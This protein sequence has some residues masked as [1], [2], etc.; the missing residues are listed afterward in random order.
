MLLRKP[1]IGFVP[2]PLALVD[3]MLT[4]AEV[5]ANDI[6]YDLGSGDG[7]I[8]I[9][10]AQCFGTRGVGLEID[11]DRLREAEV[12]VQRAGVSHLVSFRHQDLFEGNFSEATV[13]ILYLLPHLNL[14]LRPHLLHQLQPG[15]RLISRDFDMGNWLPDRV[16]NVPEPEESVLYY[17]RISTQCST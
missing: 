14:R 16:L 2:T 6:L 3:A 4:L 11:R 5:Q 12:E 15:T 9:R 8:L 17:W 13:V 10:A 7:R 1:D